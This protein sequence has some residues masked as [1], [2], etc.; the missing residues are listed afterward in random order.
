MTV[1]NS[2]GFVDTIPGWL[3]WESSLPVGLLYFPKLVEVRIFD[4]CGFVILSQAS[5]SEN[6][7][8]L[9]VCWY[10]S[11]LVKV[12]IYNICGFVNIIPDLLKW[13]SSTAVGLLIL[14]QTCWNDSL[15]Q[16]WVCWFYPSL[17]KVRI[18]DTRR[19]VNTIPDLL[20]W[21]YSTAVGL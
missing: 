14:S 21:Q 8:Y 12:R 19:F 9:W 4:T 17:V 15:Q 2:C 6:L 20:K 5:W 1:F 3:K 10:C 18:F 16:L 13:Q 7:R 11:K